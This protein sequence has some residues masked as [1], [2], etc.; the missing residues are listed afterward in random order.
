MRKLLVA[1]Q[2]SGVGKTTTS[3]NLAAAAALAGTRV[4]LLDADPLSCVA[5]ALHLATHPNRRTLRQ[6]GVDLPGVLVCD[7]VP[8][9]DVL[10]PYEA[11]PC[12][13]VD[14]GDLLRVMDA[15]PFQASYGCL[16]VDAPP[17]LG[18]NPTQLV[19]AVDGLIIVVR[20][21]PLAHRTLPAFLELVQR[22]RG[23]RPVQTHGV[24]VTLPD[25]ET[26]GG[27]WERELRGRL[28]SRALA[29]VIPFDEEVNQAAEAGR[30]AAQTLPEAPAVVQYQRLAE[31]LKLADDPFPL[32]KAPGAMAL[33]AA[34][35]AL[36][37][38]VGAAARGSAYGFSSGAAAPDVDA[39]PETP[40]IDLPPELGLPSEP[41]LPTFSGLSSVSPPS[42]TLPAF[43][44]P[45]AGVIRLATRPTGPED[46]PRAA[47][48][49]K[50]PSGSASARP[51]LLGVGLAVAVGIGLRFV[52]LPDY[53]LPIAVGIAVAAAVILAMRLIL[54]TP[55]APKAAPSV[56]AAVPARAP[57][58]ESPDV[59]KDASSRLSALARSSATGA[60]RRPRKK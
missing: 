4:L 49:P 26:P 9:L 39:P 25:A 18:A 5:D 37:E 52:Q 54:I 14:F 55:D 42:L 12:S 31:A 2:K 47:A 21:E 33:Q 29:Q 60:Y 13:D 34:A 40:D 24:L 41:E 56:T 27:R 11:G 23:D 10:S 19:G 16:V 35:A 58:K 30:I 59:R 7:V 46:E 32:K 43:R 28:G 8:G 53:M 50:P 36:L 44:P 6:A 15:P 45:P 1:S 48:A 57:K 38:P 51:W 20:A 22:S 3:I 17:F